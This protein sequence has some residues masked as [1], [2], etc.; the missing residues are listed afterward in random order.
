MITIGITGHR[1]LAEL[2]KITCGLDQVLKQIEQSFPGEDWS[3]LSPLAQGS[4]QLFVRRAILY[5]LARLIVPLPLPQEKYLADFT[6]IEAKEEFHQILLQADKVLTL[7]TCA[8]HTEAYL[9][10]AQYIL[11][12]CSVLV[13][14]WDGQPAQGE[15]GTSQV[16]DW[17]RQQQL[18]LAWVH[19]GNRL[20]GTNQPT[21]LG[22]AQGTVT[23][24]RFPEG[25]KVG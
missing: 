3:L 16:V 11:Q 22:E 5:H 1:F 6:T 7:P 4:D 20:P 8:T 19:A 24:E 10:V 25:T 12:N 21:S 15:G 13:V 23:F 18:P 9:N 17:A 14:I 2:E